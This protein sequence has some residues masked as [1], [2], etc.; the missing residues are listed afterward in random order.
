[1]SDRQKHHSVGAG[2]RIEAPI[3]ANGI[4]V[5][6]LDTAFL[7]KLSLCAFKRSLL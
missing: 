5:G 6:I 4:D 7:K 1:V 3:V 2:L